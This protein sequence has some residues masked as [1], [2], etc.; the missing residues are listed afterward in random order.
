L[1]HICFSSQ[2]GRLLFRARGVIH[3]QP[4]PIRYVWLA[5]L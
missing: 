3:P 5:F 4:G 2:Q 1:G